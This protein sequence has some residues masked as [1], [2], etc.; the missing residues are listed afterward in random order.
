VERNPDYYLAKDVGAPY[1]E[2]YVVKLFG[3]S[4]TMLAA[5]EAGDITY[6]GIEP[7]KVAKFKGMSHID[8]YTVPGGG[9][10]LIGYNHRNNGWEGLRNT[11]IRQALSMSIGKETIVRSV[12]VGFAEPAYSFIP[13]TSPWYDDGSVVKFGVGELYDKEKARE[14]FFQEGYGI[15]GDDGTIQITD[16]DGSP[17]KLKLVTN[18]GGGLAEDIAYFVKQELADIGIEVELKLVPWETLVRKYL[19]NKL[20][21]DDNPVMQNA[22]PE[23]V[24]EDS[25][26]MVLMAFGTDVLAPS[27]SSVFF[28]TDGG[29]NFIGYSNPEVD[30]LFQRVKSKEALDKTVRS[31]LYAEISRILS[32]D[33]PIDFLV[34]RRGNLGFQNNVKGVEPGISTGYNYYLWYFE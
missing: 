2:K 17:L 26:D 19:M 12:Y 14:M 5:L 25:W 30:E 3:S 22:G 7:D 11:T 6:G 21:G 29:L 33:Q 27:G 20:P 10:T 13:V 28:T 9:Y 4:A 32:E 15:K 16:K 31:Q 1:F 34:F 24:S 23:G 8:V 18:T